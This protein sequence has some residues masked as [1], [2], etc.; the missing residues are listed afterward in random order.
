MAGKTTNC[1][2]IRERMLDAAN[3]SLAGSLRQAFD[4]HLSDCVACAQEFQQ[5]QT[6]A[7]AIDHSL[8]TGLS[9]E[10][11]P[12]LIVNV[13]RQIS[14][15]A[16]HATWSRQWGVWLTAAGVCAVL[17]ILVLAV[18]SVR[19]FNRPT[20]DH[21][22]AS[23]N[24]PATPKPAVP[25]QA[26]VALQ[27][28]T[29]AQPHTLVL[30]LARH[31]SS[32]ASRRKAAEP[33]I[34]V[35]PGQ[36]QAILRLAAATQSGKVDGAKLLVGQKKADE[37]LDVKPLAVIA[38]LKI[39]VLDDQTAPASGSGENDEKDFVAGEVTTSRASSKGE[40]Q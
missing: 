5:A 19:E 31:T 30:G 11:S 34:I 7:Q 37:Q 4:A 12:R 10:P 38:P 9:V 36:M 22:V 8:S 32:R 29:T 2:E 23:I 27:A 39:A 16:N 6:L 26:K 21:A 20:H 33:E 18:R 13:R 15:Q 25:P 17:A 28:A 3:D 1:A 24:A 14:T 40:S 35:E